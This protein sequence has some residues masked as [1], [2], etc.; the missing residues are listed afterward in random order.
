M[1]IVHI[2]GDGEPVYGG[3]ELKPGQHLAIIEVEPTMTTEKL[4]AA[5]V[6]ALWEMREWAHKQTVMHNGD[7]VADKVWDEIKA[8]HGLLPAPAAAPAT[9]PRTPPPP[10]V[11]EAKGEQKPP[12]A[13]AVALACV[14][15]ERDQLRTDIAA[16][17]AERDRLAA[18][19]IRLEA[20]NET[21]SRQRRI[22]CAVA[23]ELGER[24]RAMKAARAK[25]PVRAKGATKRGKAK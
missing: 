15:S 12:S 25:K 8:R 9:D 10:H 13:D 20:E 19:V 2:F 22:A 16:I 11:A 17:T 1:K 23:T 6:E 21:L 4:V 24:L 3:C 5:K 18:E 14:R 7:G